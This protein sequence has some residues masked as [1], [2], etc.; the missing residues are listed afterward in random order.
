MG[1][2]VEFGLQPSHIGMWEGRTQGELTAEN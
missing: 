1:D 2:A